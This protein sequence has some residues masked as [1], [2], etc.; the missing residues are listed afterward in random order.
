MSDV[1]WL[2]NTQRNSMA[3]R[4]FRS[5][6][7]DKDGFG[8]SIASEAE[9]FRAITFHKQVPTESLPTPQFIFQGDKRL[10]KKRHVMASGCLI[11]SGES[12]AVL[13]AHDLGAT[14]LVPVKL[15]R[16]DRTTPVEGEWFYL[17]PGDAKPALI[18]EGAKGLHRFRKDHF[19]FMPNNSSHLKDDDIA[20]SDAVLSPPDIWFD[21]AIIEAP[22]LSDRLVRALRKAKLAAHWDLVRCRVE[23]A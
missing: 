6:D 9:T 7:A 20:F 12:A 13:R 5:M 18:D 22:I 11:V 15:F 8:P 10:D 21:P 19:L 1:V 16:R 2:C 4:G 17:L 14:R 3:E 23:T